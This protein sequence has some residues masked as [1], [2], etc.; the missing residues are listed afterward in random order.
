M[1]QKIHPHGLRVGVLK[2]WDS[3][4]YV[5]KKDFAD[6]LVEDYNLRKMLKEQLKSAGV[7]KI[8]IERVS[9]RVRIHIYCA[10]PG[11]V[12]GQKGAE[13]EKLRIQCEKKIGK[14]VSINIVEVKIPDADATLV[15]ESIALQLEKRVSFRRAMKMSIGRAMNAGVKGIKIMLSGRVGG[16]EIARSEMYKEGTTPLQTIRADI[17]YG[18]AE[19]HTTYGIV[20]VKV[21]IY[22]GEVLKDKD[23]TFKRPELPQPK[24]NDRGDRRPRRR[25]DGERRT[26]GNRRPQRREGGNQ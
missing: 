7:P 21:W 5:G 6:T 16:A 9:G 15:A 12:I 4:W 10:K 13:I 8:E 14:P 11:I 22:N 18:F 1:G 19:A 3:R 20:G 26:D 25:N 24:R 17:D 23:G 2:D